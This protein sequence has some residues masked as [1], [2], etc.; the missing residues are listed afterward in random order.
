[1]RK[2][3]FLVR[4]M[5]A[6]RMIAVW[7]IVDALPR[8]EPKS[9]ASRVTGGNRSDRRG[10]KANPELVKSFFRQPEYQYVED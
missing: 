2:K 5:G 1:M 4:Q 6:Q 8:R 7:Q 10:N 3:R 9:Q